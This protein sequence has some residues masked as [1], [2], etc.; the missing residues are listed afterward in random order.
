MHEADTRFARRGLG[1]GR[2]LGGRHL[3]PTFCAS[4]NSASPACLQV[5]S[6]EVGSAAR[7]H[8][9]D[10]WVQQAPTQQSLEERLQ[11]DELE[12]EA[13]RLELKIQR[14]ERAAGASLG[15]VKVGGAD[16]GC[17]CWLAGSRGSTTK[18]R[19]ALGR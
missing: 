19:A 5:C 8:L 6:E 15:Q 11:P 1:K 18:Q 10:M 7:A 4:S 9:L 2:L 17:M 3:R 12:K 13:R 16:K 14:Q